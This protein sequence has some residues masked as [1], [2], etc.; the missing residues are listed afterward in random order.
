[1]DLDAANAA[2]TPFV[3]I[4]P[5]PALAATVKHYFDDFCRADAILARQRWWS[6]AQR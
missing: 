3:A 6:A 5:N 1:V 2:E 4:N